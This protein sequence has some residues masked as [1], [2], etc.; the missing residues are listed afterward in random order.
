MLFLAITMLSYKW[1]YAQSYSLE[2]AFFGLIFL[3][4]LIFDRKEIFNINTLFDVIGMVN[5]PILY[6]GIA[7]VLLYIIYQKGRVG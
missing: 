4:T 6:S 1:W 2:V 7:L 3:Y 5:I